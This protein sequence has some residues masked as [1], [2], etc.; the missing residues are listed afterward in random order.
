[1]GKECIHIVYDYVTHIEK[2]HP[3]SKWALTDC[4]ILSQNNQRKGY[5][6]ELKHTSPQPL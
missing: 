2:A 1:M 4:E 6:K 5:K 3:I